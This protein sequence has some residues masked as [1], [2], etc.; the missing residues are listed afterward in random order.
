MSELSEQKHESEPTPK[1]SPFIRWRH[2]RVGRLC[3]MVLAGAIAYAFA[4]LA[5]DSGALWQWVLAIG[6]AIDAIY[7][8]V[9]LVR[10]LI[11]HEPKSDA[12]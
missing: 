9:Q 10:S 4:S 8:L 11:N 3:W 1:H 2:T 12:N 6:F 7:N 5:I